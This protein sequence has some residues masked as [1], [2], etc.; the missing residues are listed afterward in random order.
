M[1]PQTHTELN[2]FYN[3][4]KKIVLKKINLQN[5]LT[6]LLRQARL[7]KFKHVPM[8]YFMIHDDEANLFS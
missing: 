1:T 7:V 5:N 8:S 2:D 3:I 4:I 6:G